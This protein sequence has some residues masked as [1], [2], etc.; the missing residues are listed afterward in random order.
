M[1]RP[2][3][4]E[5]FMNIAK[6]VAT[7]SNCYRRQVGCVMVDVE[8]RILSTGYNGV[9]SGY[10][11]CKKGEC[12]REKN[13]PGDNL[14]I[15]LATHAE[16]NAMIQCHDMDQIFKIYVTHSPCMPCTVVLLN[17]VCLNIIYDKTYPGWEASKVVWKKL[18]R[19]WTQ[20]ETIGH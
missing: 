5:Y 19:N 8:N 2:T 7:R 4:D 14:G 13:V 6:V 16:M 17:T 12:P 11:H 20:Y 18:N 1:N 10:P 3:Q 9:P 15:C